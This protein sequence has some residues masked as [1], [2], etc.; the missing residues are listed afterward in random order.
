[1][2]EPYN[3]AINALADEFSAL[4]FRIYKDSAYEMIFS[5]ESG[6]FLHISTEKYYH[7]SV[8]TSLVNSRGN[9]FSVRGIKE[10]IAPERAAKDAQCLKL[11]SDQYNLVDANVNSV[12]EWNGIYQYVQLI[13]KQM[14]DFLIEYREAIF[15][16]PNS[17]ENE[18]QE[19]ETKFLTEFGVPSKPE[20]DFGK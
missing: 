2:I 7:P 3:T 14:L 4:G 6:Y 16:F 8:A 10:I 9:R 18:Y 15:V 13:I 20:D 12:A 1:M 17:Y 11:V 19:R 5:N